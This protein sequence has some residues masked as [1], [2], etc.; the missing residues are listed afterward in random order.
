MLKF[1]SVILLI[2]SAILFRYLTMEMT[3]I[4]TTEL[5][6][7]KTEIQLTTQRIITHNLCE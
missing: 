1:N 6:Q 4:F 7:Y 5:Q 2:T 3:G